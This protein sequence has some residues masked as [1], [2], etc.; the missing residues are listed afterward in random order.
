MTAVLVLPTS[1]HLLAQADSSVDPRLAA[2]LGPQD[3][4][5]D[6]EGPVVSLGANGNFDDQHIHAPVV[7]REGDEY[8]MWY[9]GSRGSVIDR[10]FRMGL[11][12]S[13]DGV[14]F[15]KHAAN[16]LLQFPSKWQSVLTPTL[17]C[18]LSGVPLRENGKLRMWLSSTNFR[19]ESKLHTLHETT[20]DDGLTW[21]EPSQPLLDHVYSPT[22]LKDGDVY[23][24]WY[25]DVANDP[26]CFRHATS[27]DG[28]HWQV[29]PEPVMT[30][31]QKWEQGRLFYP[32]VVK[33]DGVFLMWYG[34]YWA[35][36]RSKTAL[37]FAASLDGKQWVRS[38]YNPVFRP[39]VSRKWESHYTTSQS[40]M[41]LPD[42]TW[43]IW[44]ATRT[45][46]PFVHKYFAIGTARWDGP[47]KP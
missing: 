12:T 20:S 27:S 40:L 41:R 22:I 31:G 7:A 8:R 30:V 25:T 39:D 37:G 6:S 36:E 5:R 23:R 2:W 26:W 33:V 11:A 14:A 29:L 13:R 24:M 38:P 9:V 32:T 46:P 34:S 45:A 10:V 44:Y 16:P 19:G 42:G 47:Q 21:S 35:Q 3:W 43:K 28:R 18:D 1:N 17:L 4:K 15:E